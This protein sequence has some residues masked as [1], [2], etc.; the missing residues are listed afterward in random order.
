[1][2]GS[3]GDRISQAHSNPQAAETL[4]PVPDTSGLASITQ[5]VEFIVDIAE[6]EP[7]ELGTTA[8][9]Y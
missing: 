9:T 5:F 6:W 8:L 7:R 2:P 3:W 4:T 1:M